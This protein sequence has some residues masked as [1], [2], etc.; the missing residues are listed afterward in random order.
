[1]P[2][3]PKPE[4]VLTRVEAPPEMPARIAVDLRKSGIEGKLQAG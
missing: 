2:Q 1:L 3:L 4:F